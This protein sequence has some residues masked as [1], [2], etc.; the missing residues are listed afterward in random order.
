MLRRDGPGEGEKSKSGFCRKRKRKLRTRGKRLEGGCTS[1]FESEG[2][3]E[4]HEGGLGTM[5]IEVGP[6]SVYYERGVGLKGDS[7]TVRKEDKTTVL[8]IAGRRKNLGKGGAQRGVLK[9]G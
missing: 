6:E 5:D 1:F 9:N 3:T 2:K 7:E 8:M 4:A